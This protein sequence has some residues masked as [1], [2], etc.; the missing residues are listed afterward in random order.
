MSIATQGEEEGAVLNESHLDTPFS[1]SSDT[2]EVALA[3]LTM[4]RT[5]P[6]VYSTYS[7]S[8]SSNIPHKRIYNCMKIYD[9]EIMKSHFLIIHTTGQIYEFA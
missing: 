1:C 6:T 2:L 4:L 8:G 9:E 5:S 7:V 3:L